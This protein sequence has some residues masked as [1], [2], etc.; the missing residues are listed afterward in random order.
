MGEP[1]PGEAAKELK[2]LRA[3]FEAL[4]FRELE[5]RDDLTSAGFCLAKPPEHYVVYLPRG[6]KAEIDLASAAGK[7]L[8]GTWYDPRSGARRPAPAL[9]PGKNPVAAPAPGDWVLHAHRAGAR[10]Q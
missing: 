6:G 9:A 7:E 1:G 10:N 3:F 5:P 4:P 2:H 8:A